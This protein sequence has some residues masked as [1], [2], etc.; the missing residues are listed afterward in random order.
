MQRIIKQ[1]MS[2]NVIVMQEETKVRMHKR[3]RLSLKLD[4][5]QVEFCLTKKDIFLCTKMN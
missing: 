3:V 5:V 1:M 4:L 2:P